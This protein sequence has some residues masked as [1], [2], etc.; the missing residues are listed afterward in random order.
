MAKGLMDRLMGNP[1]AKD[2]DSIAA[3]LPAVYQPVDD[4]I[5]KTIAAWREWDERRLQNPAEHAYSGAPQRSGPSYFE[6][7]AVARRGW[8]AVLRGARGHAG[9]S[10]RR[11]IPR[12]I[13]GLPSGG[14]KNGRVPRTRASAPRFPALVWPLRLGA[15][16]RRRDL[17]EQ[18]A[19][20]ELPGKSSP[21]SAGPANVLAA[22]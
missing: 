11:G 5:K 21:P 16:R 4:Q 2:L 12:G 15:D 18:L 8:Q 20:V 6:A 1:A 13:G 7:Q 14:R 9:R 10:D 22:G 3:G 17:A 19:D